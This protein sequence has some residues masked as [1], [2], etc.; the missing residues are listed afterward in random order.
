MSVLAIIP[1]RAGSKGIPFKN[2]RELVGITPTQRAVNVARAAGLDP[3]VSADVAFSGHE[4][5]AF[6]D[7]TLLADAPVLARPA[8]LAQDDTPM[9]DVVKHVLSGIPG[10]PDQI[11]VLLQPTAPLRTPAHVV[12][13]IDLLRES[14]ADS[15]VSVVEVPL[16][17]NPEMLLVRGR[18]L[19]MLHPWQG[20]WGSMH[21][22][23]QDVLRNAYMRDGTVYA[24]RRETVIV[25]GNVYGRAVMPLIIPAS[26]SCAL[27]TPEDW[28]EA[29]RRLRER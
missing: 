27:D 28:A 12:A 14:Q 7:L 3:I 10:P 11:V 4:L 1:A 26:E 15:V 20:T 17:Q 16:A 8:E 29:E 13:A 21:T 22:R 24:F 23:R 25:Y 2:F 6:P 18:K 19:G 9:V 5:R